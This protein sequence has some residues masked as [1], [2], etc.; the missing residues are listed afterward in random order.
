[1]T[2]VLT[3]RQTVWGWRYLGFQLLFLPGLLTLANSL[4]GTPLDAPG[5]NLVY[6]SIN[7]LV[8][9]LLFGS[10]LREDLRKL[11]PL[12]VLAAACAALAVYWAASYG[13]GLLNK[14]LYP[15]FFNINDSSIAH[16]ADSRFWLTA[17]GTVLLVPAAEELLYRG[18]LFGTL[19]RRNRLAAY[20][21]SVLIFALIHVMSYIG[22]YPTDLLA[23]CLLQYV[24]AGLC[25]AWAYEMSDSIFCP[26]LMHCVINAIGL[27]AT[28]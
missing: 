24:P 16:M 15:D 25:L 18:V 17:V 5:L 26:I 11:K 1:M 12:R 4:L 9:V 27:F 3:Q 28:R 20:G 7:F 21:V 6:F 2:V 8:T 10:F 19:R 23:L 22:S 13:V 14:W